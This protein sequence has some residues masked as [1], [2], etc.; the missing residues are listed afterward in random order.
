MIAAMSDSGHCPQPQ[1]D[2]RT[3]GGLEARLRSSGSLACSFEGDGKILS[4]SM[5]TFY[6]GVLK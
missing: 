2:A 4:I 1:G 6:L 3:L 5:A